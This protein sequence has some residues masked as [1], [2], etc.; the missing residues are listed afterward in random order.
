MILIFCKGHHPAG[1]GRCKEC[2]D[3]AEYAATCVALCPYGA[4]KPVCG[5]CPANCFRNGM[6]EKMTEVMR[7][8][9]PRMLYKHPVLTA[10]HI[11][12]ACKRHR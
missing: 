9:G 11:F 1:G 2:A 10:R 3:L 7:Y 5:R 6:L 8:A 12:A 4:S